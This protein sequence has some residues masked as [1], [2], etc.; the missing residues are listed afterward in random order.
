MK[1]ESRQARHGMKE[2]VRWKPA[3]HLPRFVQ[4]WNATNTRKRALPTFLFFVRRLFEHES[5][6]ERFKGEIARARG[7][8]W[9]LTA[10]ITNKAPK[11]INGTNAVNLQNFR[12]PSLEPKTEHKVR[13]KKAIADPIPLPNANDCPRPTGRELLIIE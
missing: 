12:I 9:S 10:P 8:H 4:P 1:P 3:R 13:F 6:P 11:M 2:N 5:Q 7:C